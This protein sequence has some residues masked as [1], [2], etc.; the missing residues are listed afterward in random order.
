MVIV[1]EVGM[2]EFK[3]VVVVAA[4][5][6]VLLDVTFDDCMK[7]DNGIV[8]E[9]DWGKNDDVVPPVEVG[10]EMISDSDSIIQ[11]FIPL[12]LFGLLLVV[13]NAGVALSL[14]CFEEEEE[15]D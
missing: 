1:D 11:V 13:V 8:D 2:S 14:S 7:D 3:R 10:A 12:V 6:P 15:E 9:D 4:S 5:M